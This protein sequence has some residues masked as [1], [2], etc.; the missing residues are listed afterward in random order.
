[1]DVI[2][3]RFLDSGSTLVTMH[4]KA[5]N[6]LKWFASGAGFKHGDSKR[7]IATVKA[8]GAYKGRNE[9]II[10]RAKAL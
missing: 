2:D 1:M 10:T 8:H 4:D 6:V 5:G 9:T 7:I 3:S